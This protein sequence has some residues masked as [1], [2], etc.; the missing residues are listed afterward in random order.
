MDRTEAAV[1]KIRIKETIF[2]LEKR[3]LENRSAT[4]T[5][6]PIRKERNPPMDLDRSIGIKSKSA[7]RE[8]AT[9]VKAAR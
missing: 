5:A 3:E 2:F 4:R 6:I 1:K 9:I 8:A 7:I